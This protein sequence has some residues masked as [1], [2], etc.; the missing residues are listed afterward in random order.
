MI[1]TQNLTIDYGNDNG[2][3]DVDLMIQEG[4]IYAL[5]GP[6]GCGKTTLL[7]A[8]AGL[9]TYDNG[10]IEITNRQGSAAKLGLVQ[11]KDALFPWLK[12]WENTVLGLS[13]DKHTKLPVAI[14]QLKALEI[15]EY[16]E[17]YP[18]QLSGGQRQRVS[19]ARTLVSEPDVLLL[20]EPTA[21]LDAFS[22]EALQDLLLKLHFNKARTTLFVTHSIEEALYLADK[23]LIMDKGRIKVTYDNP[24]QHSYGLRDEPEFY[25]QVKVLRTLMNRGGM[26]G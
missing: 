2:M 22:K 14:S 4:E 19:I 5:I 26:S 6:S 17:V 25:E 18:A 1:K 3:F 8:L 10:I 11:Q 12:V 23:I 20:D 15:D 7:H 16:L 13:G 24:L 9:L 21:S